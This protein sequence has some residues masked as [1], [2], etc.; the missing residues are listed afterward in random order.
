MSTK[1]KSSGASRVGQARDELVRMLNLVPYFTRHTDRTV[2]EAA[3]DFGVS[4]TQIVEDL[5]RLQCCGP[6]TYP[7]ELV[8]LDTDRISVSIEDTQGLDK[9]VRLTATE[10][11]SL[12]LILESLE[13]IDGLIDPLV[14]Q[15]TTDKLREL[16]SRSATAI[17]SLPDIADGQTSPELTAT[18]D[19]FKEAFSQ[20]KKAQFSYYNRYSDETSE[21]TVDV[22]QLF[23]HDGITYLHCYDNGAKAVRTFRLDGISD[24]RLS[25]TPSRL[26]RSEFE[27]DLSAPFDFSGAVV[28]AAIELAP[29]VRWLADESP[30]SIVGELPGGRAAAELPLVSPDWLIRFSLAYGGKVVVTNPESVAT[31]VRKRAE[32]A[33]EKYL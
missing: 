22:L 7:D 33:L 15:S 26:P 31:D 29:D 4:P 25:D 20:R 21:R 1:K 6:G 17:E 3:S 24:A 28:T 10:A 11:F 8:T 5:L 12:L 2:F 14:V 32:T 23:T 27:K 30:M 13:G 19:T 9:S 16:T 18:V